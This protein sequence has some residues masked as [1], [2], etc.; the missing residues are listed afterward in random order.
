M[1]KAK[2]MIGILGISAALSLG[3]FG[4]AFA[5]N[6]EKDSAGWWYDN[7]DGTYP[8]SAWQHIDGQWY[9]FNANGYMVTG[10]QNISGKWYYFYTDGSMASNTWID[11]AYYVDADGEWAQADSAKKYSDE[12]LLRII[13]AASPYQLIGTPYTADFNGDGRRE[14]VACSS[15]TEE[16][17]S[18]AWTLFYWYTDGETTY[19]FGDQEMMGWIYD[20][21]YTA[22][23]TSTGMDL[24][25]NLAWHPM[26]FGGY[27]ECAYIYRLTKD[28]GVE[29]L[30][31]DCCQLREPQY[32]SIEAV[33]YQL[34]YGMG[35]VS[36]IERLH[37]SG[38]KYE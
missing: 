36:S 16:N 13:Q 2:K 15:D 6:W 38:M 34:S 22:I 27:M 31:R 11:G 33:N 17:Q 21:A 3:V 23:P 7:L 24:A 25:V 5:G 26:A 37:L 28:G 18:G 8:A 9:Y 20:V 30:N 12:E 32:E 35:D 14:M 29:M 19:R 1:K 10:W 4:S